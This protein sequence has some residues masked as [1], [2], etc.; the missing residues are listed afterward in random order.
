[1]VSS[2]YA[3]RSPNIVT[4]R[5]PKRIRH[6]KPRAIAL[7][8]PAVVDHRTSRAPSFDA[9]GH[10]RR[11]DAADALWRELVRRARASES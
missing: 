2:D 5:A 7:T 9:D 11:G 3:D 4:A 10:R 1:M 8:V 6:P